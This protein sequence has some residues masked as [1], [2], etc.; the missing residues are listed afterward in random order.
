MINGGPSVL[1]QE[2]EFFLSD[3]SLAYVLQGRGRRGST[4]SLTRVDETMR[5]KGHSGQ[6]SDASRARRPHY[7]R[8][9]RELWLGRK[10]V[11]RFRQRAPDQ[12][13]ILSAFE[14]QNWW[15]RIDSP[16]PRDNYDEDRKRRLNHAIYRLNRH[17]TNWLIHFRGDG[18]EDGVIWERWT[19]N[20]RKA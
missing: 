11:K 1:Q 12:H 19:R 4:S 14:E 9:L 16:L 5:P 20:R 15:R 7:D 2:L 6:L 10:L 17:Q 3:Q 8:D 18:T 13:L